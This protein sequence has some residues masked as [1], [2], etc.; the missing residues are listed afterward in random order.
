MISKF[1]L[2]AY[3]EGYEVYSTINSKN[4]LAANSALKEGI[5]KYEVRHGYKKPDNFVDL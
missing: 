3:K 2:A 1:G 4:Q 5:E